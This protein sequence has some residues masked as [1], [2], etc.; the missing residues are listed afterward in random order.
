MANFISE[1]DIEK[2]FLDKLQQQGWQLLNCYTADRDNLK[3]SSNRPDKRDVILLDR[4]KAAAIRLN[5][6]LL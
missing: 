1:D 4:L 5:P 2:A 3:D 6:H